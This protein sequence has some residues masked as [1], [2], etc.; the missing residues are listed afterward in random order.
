[1][2]E[3]GGVL[4]RKDLRWK[5]WATIF[6]AFLCVI[7]VVLPYYTPSLKNLFFKGQA[8]VRQG[9][10]LQGG[11]EVILTPDYRVER[12]VLTGIMDDLRSA[13]T[14]IDVTSPTIRLL[15][16]GEQNRYE[17][18]ELVFANGEEAN[19]VLRAG[20]IRPEMTWRAGAE[21]KRLKLRAEVLTEKPEVL[22]V[23]VS[24]DPRNYPADALAQAR[25]IIERRINASGLTEPAVWLD[26]VNQ[27]LQIQLPGITTQ[28]EAERLIRTTGRLNFRLGNRIV[29]F[30]TD[31]TEARAD[32]D[33]REG[34]PVIHFKFGRVGA[35]QFEEITREHVGEVLAIYLDEEL[36]MEPLI[37]EPIP[38]G[39]GQITLG[40]GAT[41]KEAQEYAVLMKSGALPV[42]LRTVQI[43][44]VA[45]TL[46]S[47]IVRQSLLAM[48]IGL[49]LVFLFMVGFYG[50]PG[51]LADAALIL[52]GLLVMGIMALFRGVLTLPGVAGFILSIG[53][54]VDANILIF[55][56]IKDEI[57]NGKT[58]RTALAAGFDRAFTA[59][60]DA[61]VTTLIVALVLLVLGT[62][63]VRGFAVTLTIGIL[64]SMFT[65]LV[66]TRIFMEIA[67][68]RNPEKLFKR[69]GGG[70]VQA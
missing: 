49:I 54:A 14:S 66:V 26:E 61:N 10:D 9:L 58:M 2:V 38:G 50:I 41:L 44:Q 32:I 39:E 12:R 42:S 55:E 24:E 45:P 16:R 53:M 59:I 40:R 69:L 8:P 15:G 37:R 52:Y 64:V 56:R 28:E 48:V 20:V 19:R 18:L 43:T 68:D 65:A 22:Q 27:R 5:F 51:L 31:L 3:E 23:Y 35:R 62:G 21:E 67:V 30:G 34:V 33:P 13:V 11:I 29:M 7:F 70:E 47:E 4:V 46:G 6:L 17:G 60:L 25:I 63:T 57:W 1:M 36:L